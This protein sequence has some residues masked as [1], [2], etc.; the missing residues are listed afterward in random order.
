MRLRSRETSTGHRRE[1]GAAAVLKTTFKMAFHDIPPSAGLQAAA[2]RWVS[3]LEQVYD[4]IAGCFVTIERPHRGHLSASPFQIRITIGVPG[5]R[6]S[7]A[8][9]SSKDAYVAIADAF[10][11]ARKQL[12]EFAAAA[13]QRGAAKPVPV[14]PYAGLALM[15]Y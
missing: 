2:E 5:T 14:D 1:R 13:Q 9:Q 7:V 3:R 8:H 10:R 11:D 12:L 4:Q 15:K 6:L